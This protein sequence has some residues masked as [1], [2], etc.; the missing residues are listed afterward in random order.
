[1]SKNIVTKY[2]RT[3]HFLDIRV[4]ICRD[5]CF[6]LFKYLPPVAPI[7]N[8]R[9]A[10]KNVPTRRKPT[11]RINITVDTLAPFALLIPQLF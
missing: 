4:I 1:M 3:T 8:N 2:V 9:Q 6:F 11:I 5:F 10:N 7:R